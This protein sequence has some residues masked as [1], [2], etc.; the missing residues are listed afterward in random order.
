VHTIITL[1]L[2]TALMKCGLYFSHNLVKESDNHVYH[3]SQCHKIQQFARSE[4]LFF[5]VVSRINNNKCPE[6]HSLD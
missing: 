4:C 2:A 5:E 1:A 3:P 6:R